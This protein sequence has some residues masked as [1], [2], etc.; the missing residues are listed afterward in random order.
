MSLIS[1][2]DAHL[3]NGADKL[4]DGADLSVEENERICLVGRNGTGKSTL[5]SLIE[6][7]RELDSGRIIVQNGLK[8]AALHQD[9]PKYE[10]GTVYSLAATGVPVVGEALAKFFSCTDPHEQMELSSFIDKHDGWAKDAVI[11]KVLNRI[12]LE[13]DTPLA[14][15]SGGNRRKA[16]L[17]VALTSEPKLLLLDEPTN[18]LD[19]E[20]IIWFEEEL[21]KFDGTI[22]FVTHDRSFA[23]SCATR[24]VELDRGLMYSYPGSFSKYIELRD[25]RLRKEELANIEFDK[26][27][28]EEEAWI[29]RGVKARLA[30]NEGRVRDLKHLREV[31]ANRRDR[32][33]N[34]IME[35]NEAARSG[36]LIY[37]IKDISL[38]FDGKSIFKNFSATVMRGDRIGITGPNGAGKTTLIKTLLGQ[39]KPT[40]GKIKTGVNLEIQY[41]DQYHEALDLDKSVADNVAD[42]HTEV[43]INGKS[44]HVISYLANFLFTG[45]RARSPVRVLS[46]GEKNRL[47]LARLFARKSNLLI[48]DEPTNDLDLETL[49][50]LED[51]IANYE[52]TVIVIS[53]DR[54]FIDKVAT[55]TW[56]FDG[57]GEI[58][59]VIGGWS[60]VLAYYERVQ[61][62]RAEKELTENKNSTEGRVVRVDAAVSEKKSSGLSFT[63]KHELEKIPARVEDLEDKI[64]ALDEKLNDP[65]IYTDG[66]ATAKEISD[67]RSKLVEELDALYSRWEELEMLSEE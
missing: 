33:G 30:R 15:L 37:E 65:S 60:D 54:Q 5:L 67:E 19:I 58:E 43:T 61:K 29:R 9:P 39:I 16:A 32:L 27:L 66:G 55:E 36:N 22:I 31:R 42:G 62:A 13:P 28:A 51:L 18:H 44:K 57:N 40:Q 35:A 8:I 1:I 17:A 14:D 6:G 23:D 63:Q 45:R 38:S 41:F 10:S 46:G 48:M 12:G 21:K 20:S 25:E 56:V 47:L 24:I 7:K 52:G 4:L 3:T 50:L 2:I 59:S 64:S 34:V 49:E 26:I 53:H 11:K